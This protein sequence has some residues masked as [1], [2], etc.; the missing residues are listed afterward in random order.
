MAFPTFVLK[1]LAG[2][3]NKLKKTHPLL[4][5]LIRRGMG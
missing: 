1:V 3:S 5:S 2:K 4:L